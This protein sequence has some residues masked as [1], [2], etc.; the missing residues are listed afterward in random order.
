MAVERLLLSFP[1]SKNGDGN[2]RHHL[3]L[4]VEPSWGPWRGKKEADG[5]GGLHDTAS[6]GRD[7]IP[8]KDR[9]SIGNTDT[10]DESSNG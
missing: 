9:A 8:N 10:R 1:R 2:L 4:K 5:G 6:S 7:P 3:P